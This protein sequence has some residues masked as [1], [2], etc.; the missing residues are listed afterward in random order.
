MCLLGLFTLTWSL[1]EP[2]VLSS[3][4]PPALFLVMGETERWR[5]EPQNKHEPNLYPNWEAFPD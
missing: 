2:E 3:R 1:T 5:R 4:A